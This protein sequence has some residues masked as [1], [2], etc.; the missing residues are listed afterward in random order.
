MAEETKDRILD[1]AQ[2]L[3]FGRGYASTSVAEIIRAVDIAKGTFYH[4]F[5]SKEE[6]LDEIV[7]RFT[8]EVLAAVMPI[9]ND[10]KMRADEKLGEFFVRGFA[11]KIADVDR[12]YGLLRAIYSD[13][14][15]LFRRKVTE[16]TTLL[17]S[18]ILATMVRQGVEEGV[19]ET[20]IPDRAGELALRLATALTEQSAS[21]FLELLDDPSAADR[22]A[23]LSSDIEYAV[24]RLI[25]APEGTISILNR[26]D[27][28]RLAEST[29]A[30]RKE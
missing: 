21:L 5:S 17:V 2:Q 29:A 16:R 26:A 23:E 28:Y 24:E 20:P 11:W 30:A 4:H 18:P 10:P 22:I 7:F 15:L 12:F 8:D 13:E 27:L 19:F 6:L 9:V 1:A 14:N 3:F 25:G